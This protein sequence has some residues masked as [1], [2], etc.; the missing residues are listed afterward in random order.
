MANVVDSEGIGEQI[1]KFLSLLQTAQLTSIKKINTLERKTK[2]VSSMNIAAVF[3][4]LIL[5]FTVPIY[6]SYYEIKQLRRTIDGLQNDLTILQNSK[7]DLD[8]LPKGIIVA[9]KSK[10]IPEG[11]AYC[12]G[13]NNTPDLRNRFI[14]GWNEK[15]NK[16]LQTGG[17][18]Q[19]TLTVENLPK[20]T[21]SFSDF[22]VK[23]ME[24]THMN[25]GCNTVFQFKEQMVK[26]QC[27][28]D[29]YSTTTVAM[30]SE[31]CKTFNT[32]PRYVVLAY[33]MK[34]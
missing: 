26:K 27:V 31:D 10:N 9:W 24:N 5:F 1:K 15:N 33:I 29:F 28:S 32:I 16:L 22:N 6:W 34:L 19:H 23:G 11:W 4:A 14:Y 2:Y 18:H 7:L 25:E 30:G 3:V 13:N 12:D 20:H 17:K 8:V 21:H